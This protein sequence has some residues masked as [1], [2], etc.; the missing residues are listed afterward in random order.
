MENQISV[1]IVD[2]HSMV[3]A[4][5]CSIFQDYP[6]IKVV[7]SAPDAELALAE[8]PCIKPDVV[9]VDVRLKGMD[10]FGLCR[11]L[12][13]DTEPP[14]ILMLT[15]YGEADNILSAI[16]AGADGY[17]LKDSH[18]DVLV[19]AIT[20]VAAGG[21]VW[22][23][24]TV[25]TFREKASNKQTASTNMLEKLSPQETRVLALISEGKTNKEISQL[26]GTA[27]KTVRNQVSNLMHKLDASRRSQAAAY[28]VKHCI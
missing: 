10:G 4:G 25:S 9:L 14:R 3:R 23:S 13:S 20:T 8:V 24:Q 18:D 15:S 16:S 22:P 7:G 26:M 12:K 2:D 28:Y 21:S 1:Y 6:Q 5:L 19:A 11:H 17:V 27:E